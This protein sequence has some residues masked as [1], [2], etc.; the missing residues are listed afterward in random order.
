M[1]QARSNWG[2]SNPHCSLERLIL[3]LF[4]TRGFT[5]RVGWRAVAVPGKREYPP[6]AQQYTLFRRSAV[7]VVQCIRQKVARIKVEPGHVSGRRVIFVQERPATLTSGKYVDRK[8]NEPDECWNVEMTGCQFNRAGVR[9]LL[10]P[11]SLVLV[12]VG[13][14]ATVRE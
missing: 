1:V 5:R 8:Y 9:T 12:F 11:Y 13:L 3:K 4:K 7:I 14:S 6:F 2:G 10:I